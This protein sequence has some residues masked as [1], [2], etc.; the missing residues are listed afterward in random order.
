MDVEVP[1][2]SDVDHCRSAFRKLRRRGSIDFGVLSVAA[3]LWTDSAQQIERASLVL[4]SVAS[5]PIAVPEA[6]SLL[7]GRPLSADTIRE[8]AHLCR[9]AATPLDNTDFQA[10][11]RSKM[12]EVYATEAL[13]ACA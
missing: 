9:R 3:A 2:E 12:V 6:E 13:E 8:A 4:G 11:W 10:Q 5:S 7:V 1:S